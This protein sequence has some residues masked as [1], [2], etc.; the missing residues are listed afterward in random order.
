MLG[1]RIPDGQAAGAA[2]RLA[3]GNV[4]VEAIGA[5]MRVSPHLHVTE[6]D[7]DSLFVEPAAIS[8]GPRRVRPGLRA[9]CGG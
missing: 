5:V 3:Q 7:L 4:H 8:S 6:A 9:E 2:Q 1:I